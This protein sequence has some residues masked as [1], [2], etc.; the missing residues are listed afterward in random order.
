VWTFFGQGEVECSSDTD[1]YNFDQ[2]ML[3]IFRI[4]W[5]VRTDKEGG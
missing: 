5:C 4:L 2:K 1:V 3:Q